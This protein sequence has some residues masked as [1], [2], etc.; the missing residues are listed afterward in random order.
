MSGVKWR[1]AARDLLRI[2]RSVYCTMRTALCSAASVSGLGGFMEACDA[3]WT[4][5]MTVEGR[6]S[7]F[8]V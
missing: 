7:P 5:D 2:F 8:L 6:D 1:K 3:R 4:R